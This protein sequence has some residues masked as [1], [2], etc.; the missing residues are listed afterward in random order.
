MGV[1]KKL[2]VTR[3][4]VD[5]ASGK[6][7]PVQ[8]TLEI[9]VKPGWKQG[10]RVTFQGKGDERPGMPAGDL[11]FVVQEKPHPRFRREGNDLHATLKVNDIS[12]L[13]LVPRLLG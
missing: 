12:P 13:Q 1:K 4:I 8:E 3:D 7:M 9:D 2:R 10:T 11:V 5:S 6:A